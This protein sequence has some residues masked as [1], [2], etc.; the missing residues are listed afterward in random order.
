MRKTEIKPLDPELYEPIIADALEEDL[1][2]GDITTSSLAFPDN[3]ASAELIAKQKGILAGID[4]FSRVFM[5]LDME[6]SNEDIDLKF[7]DGDS[8]SSGDV[9]AILNL[10]PTTLLKGERVALNF[11]AHLSGIATLTHSIV[12]RI[13][14]GG[15]LITD[16]RKTTPG[17]RILEKYAVRVGGGVNHRLSLSH[18]VLIKNNHIALVGGVREAARQIRKSIGHTVKIEVETSDLNDVR[19]A[20]DSEVDIIMLDNFT[21]ELAREAVRLIK[22]QVIVELSGGINENNF[23][24]YINSGVDIISIGALTHS[25]RAIDMAIHSI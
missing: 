24:N 6:V 2:Y 7:Y 21:P 14:E 8:F 15:P 4:V 22:K 10:K 18:S 16:T 23:S 1:S 17:L 9:L 13:P 12:S 3:A 19:E 20:L 5:M 25:V 11:L